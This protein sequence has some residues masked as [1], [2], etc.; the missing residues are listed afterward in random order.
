MLH[1]VRVTLFSSTFPWTLNIYKMKRFWPNECWWFDT[2]VS[3][4]NMNNNIYQFSKNV[5]CR[6]SLSN[7]CV[8]TNIHARS[9][10]IL[11]LSMQ[12]LHTALSFAEAQHSS[13]KSIKETSAGAHTRWTAGGVLFSKYTSSW[14]NQLADDGGCICE[15]WPIIHIEQIKHPNTAQHQLKYVTTEVTGKEH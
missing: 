10:K 11:C 6:L 15:T 5:K 14:G 9:C 3:T 12:I 13:I 4:Q 7:E 8:I 2:N 1:T